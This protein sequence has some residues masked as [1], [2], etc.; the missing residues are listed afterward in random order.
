[1]SVCAK[2][3][4]HSTADLSESR[5]AARNRLGV[6]ATRRGRTRRSAARRVTR[7][8]ETLVASRCKSAH[9]RRVVAHAGWSLITWRDALRQRCGRR[10]RVKRLLKF[11]VGGPDMV[12]EARFPTAMHGSSAAWRQGRILGKASSWRTVYTR[13]LILPPPPSKISFRVIYCTFYYHLY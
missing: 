6:G 3:F 10:G 12:P 5:P 13:V 4:E 2:N 7:A 8:E 11:N 1:M 9:Q